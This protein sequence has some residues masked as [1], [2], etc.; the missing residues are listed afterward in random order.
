[1][2]CI[3]IEFGFV[4]QVFFIFSRMFSECKEKINSEKGATYVYLIQIYGP[5]NCSRMC[6]CIEFLSQVLKTSKNAHVFL[7]LGW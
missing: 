2:V 4:N 3:R 5:Q 7:L 1:M 6:M